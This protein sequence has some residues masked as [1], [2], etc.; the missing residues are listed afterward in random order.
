MGM[1]RPAYARGQ[2]SFFGRRSPPMRNPR[3]PMSPMNRPPPFMPRLMPQGPQMPMDGGYDGSGFMGGLM[4][5]MPTPSRP[6]PLM[7]QQPMPQMPMD[8]TVYTPQIPQGPRMPQIPIPQMPMPPMQR[9]GGP[10]KG[11]PRGGLMRRGRGRPMPGGPGK[12]RGQPQMPMPQ[13][14][15]MGKVGNNMPQPPMEFPQPTARP[16]DQTMG[17]PMPQPNFMPM[18]NMEYGMRFYGGGITDLY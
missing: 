17:R 3:M 18:R 8:E 14:P 15:F 5:K 11:R 7:T 10:G 4:A 6:P 13:Q 12:G 1:G 9:P 2:S 16:V